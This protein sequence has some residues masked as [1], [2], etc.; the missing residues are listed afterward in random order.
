MTDYAYGYC[1]MP[2]ALC[3]RYRTEGTSRCPGCSHDG[4]YTDVCKAHH[5]CREKGLA[6]CGLCESFPCARLGKMS[7]FRDLTT[8]NVKQRT[9]RAIAENGFDA[10]YA[11]YAER[12]ELLTQALARYN[13]GRMKRYLCELFIRR[14]ISALR[15]IMRKAEALAGAPKEIGPAFRAFAEETL[16]GG[17]SS[18][19]SGE[20]MV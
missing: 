18:T 4:Y 1:G 10:W 19:Q 14:D 7:D 5:C 17:I 16:A 8:D 6:H 20:T 11:E 12:A 3:P 15:D 13:N 2:C 9:C